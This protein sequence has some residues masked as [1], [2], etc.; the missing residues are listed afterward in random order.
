MHDVYLMFNVTEWDIRSWCW[1]HDLL[2]MQHYKETMSVYCYKSVTHPDMTLAVCQDVKLQQDV[3]Y[4]IPYDLPM[5]LRY[6]VS[7]D[8]LT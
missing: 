4:S 2:V 6:D 3:P 8:V 5:V 7:Y 1:Q